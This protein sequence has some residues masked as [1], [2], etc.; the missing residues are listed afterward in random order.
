[1]CVTNI[2]KFLFV[3]FVLNEFYELTIY[4]FRMS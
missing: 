1:M 2:L 4:Q 3:D